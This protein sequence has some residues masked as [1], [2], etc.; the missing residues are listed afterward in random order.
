MRSSSFSG[1][2]LSLYINLFLPNFNDLLES[3]QGVY[4][5]YFISHG[6]YFLIVSS[7]TVAAAALSSAEWWVAKSSSLLMVEVGDDVDGDGWAPIV[8]FVEGKQGM[9]ART[10]EVVAP[11]C[12]QAPKR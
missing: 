5:L 8:M 10:M 4:S 11:V 2:C 1:Q 7:G 6:G 3:S 12:C 9:V